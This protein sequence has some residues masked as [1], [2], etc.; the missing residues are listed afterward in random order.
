MKQELE[1]PLCHEKVYSELGKGCKMC[2]MSL[3]DKSK[4]FCSKLCRN[5]YN[6]INKLKICSNTKLG[7]GG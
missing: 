3:V 1:C 2:G 6:K 5:L 7:V 4:D